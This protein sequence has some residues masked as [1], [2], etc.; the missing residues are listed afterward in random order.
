MIDNDVKSI[1][2]QPENGLIMKKWTGDLQDNIL[3]LGKF[4]LSKAVPIFTFVSYLVVHSNCS[5]WSGRCSTCGT[6]L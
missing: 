3:E 1:Q 2:M 4:L 6:V 5:K